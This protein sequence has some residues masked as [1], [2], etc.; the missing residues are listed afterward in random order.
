MWHVKNKLFSGWILR[1]FTRAQHAETKKRNIIGIPRSE[2]AQQFEELEL[3]STVE[4]KVWQW[5][6]ARGV[7]SFEEIPESEIGKLPKVILSQHYDIQYGNLLQ[8]S[9][10]QDTTQK[11]L[12]QYDPKNSVE[13]EISFT[14]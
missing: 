7:Q 2:L 4:K 11:W 8:H 5:I 3:K 6:Y 13:S 12:L 1:I 9:A 10:S 14:D